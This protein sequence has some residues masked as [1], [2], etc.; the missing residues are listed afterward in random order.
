MIALTRSTEEDPGRGMYAAVRLDQWSIRRV[1]KLV[2]K[3]GHFLSSKKGGLHGGK[4]E[5]TWNF[6]ENL[7]LGPLMDNVQDKAPLILRLL[8]ASA[9]SVK[10]IDE[11]EYL[12]PPLPRMEDVKSV[13]PT[14]RYSDR[15][16]TA[17]PE[18]DSVK[19]SERP[20]VVSN[21]QF[22]PSMYSR[23]IH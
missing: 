19:E 4:P 15:L 7:E 22:I 18:I 17:D 6:I 16:G 12:G 21:T 8:S 5:N 3:E 13:Q 23:L 1:T 9:A 10:S 20:S 14:A 11:F 2:W